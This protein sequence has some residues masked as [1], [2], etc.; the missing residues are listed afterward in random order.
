M[1]EGI[2]LDISK[3]GNYI[4]TIDM[5]DVPDEA[6]AYTAEA[7]VRAAL[8]INPDLG[9]GKYVVRYVDGEVE[10]GSYTVIVSYDVY[11]EKKQ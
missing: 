9:V 8:A 3:D 11:A 1:K 7:A 10:V 4:E 6:R 2:S 5:S